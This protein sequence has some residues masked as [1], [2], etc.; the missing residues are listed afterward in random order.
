MVGQRLHHA[1]LGTRIGTDPG[2]TGH[3]GLEWS[4]PAFGLAVLPQNAA[5]PGAHGLMLR[6]LVTK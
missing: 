4:G 2:V 6:G 3:G 5:H 1:R